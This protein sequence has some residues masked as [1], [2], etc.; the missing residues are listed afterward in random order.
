MTRWA[1]ANNVHKHKP[2][3]ATPW[4]QLRGGGQHQ[5]ASKHG[6]QK[7]NLGGG[8]S[9]GAP[10]RVPHGD[11]LRG[12]HP[13]GSAVK[14]P[15]RPKKDYVSEDVNGFLEFLQQSGQPLPRGDGGGGR[16][17]REE[18][19][20]ALKKDRRREDRRV[21]R[22]SDKRSNMVSGGTFRTKELLKNY[23]LIEHWTLSR[24]W[25][26]NDLKR[27]EVKYEVLGLQN[28]GNI[29]SVF[30]LPSFS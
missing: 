25:I 13:S 10:H 2:A 22:Q 27:Y 16:G 12:T 1:R 24:I 3:E 17:L 28:D 23:L 11:H 6:P 18:V 21:K 26:K 5:G 20:T 9:G 8:G 4:T 14:K 30:L 7:D 29:E 19:E 15:N